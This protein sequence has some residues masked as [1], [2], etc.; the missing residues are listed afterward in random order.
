M[1]KTRIL[2]MPTTS[3][4]CIIQK[5]TQCLLQSPA[6]KDYAIKHTLGQVLNL[7]LQPHGSHI[8]A[9]GD[10]NFPVARLQED[11]GGE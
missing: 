9:E 6:Q 10:E 1:R 11:V 5:I 2:R 8:T 3:R 7:A 4:T